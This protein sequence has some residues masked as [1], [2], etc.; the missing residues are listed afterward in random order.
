VRDSETEHCEHLLFE[1]SPDV[2]VVA[3]LDGR[4]HRVNPSYERAFGCESHEV[5]GRRLVEGVHESD[6]PAYARAF[7][8]LM[9]GAAVRDVVLRHRRKDGAWRR[10]EWNASPVLAR[11]LVYA[12]A[13]DVTESWERDASLRRSKER[14]EALHRVGLELDQGSDA[15]LRE[16]LRVAASSLEADWGTIGRIDGDIHRLVHQWSR[17]GVS[18]LT[19][20]GLLAR[21]VASLGADEDGVVAIERFAGS[22]H[23]SHPAH[24]DQGIG[25]HIGCAIRRDGTVHATVGFSAREAR[26]SPWSDDDREFLRLVARWID[27]TLQRR[28]SVR[29]LHLMARHDGLTGLLNRAA[30][31]QGIEHAIHHSQ[32]YGSALCVLMMDID[33]FKAINDARGHVTGDHVLAATAKVLKKSVRLADIAARY[34]GD[35]FCLV[36]PETTIE[37]ARVV[38]ERLRGSIRLAEFQTAAEAPV[39]VSIGIARLHERDEP[40]E[41][42]A[43]ADGALYEA[44]RGGRDRICIADEVVHTVPA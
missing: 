13:R 44:K 14:I 9:S 26:P 5:I 29:R 24:R 2:A 18:P 22:R 38:A 33:H 35:E 25:A 20:D 41:A 6:R 16:A 4:L 34:G 36:M 32:R 17:E 10:L 12:V 43:R 23:A 7:Q 39:T 11:D 21:S 37:G 8:S 1:V 3:D 27:A 15:Q 40:E 42:I 28:E 30:L 19:S 31:L